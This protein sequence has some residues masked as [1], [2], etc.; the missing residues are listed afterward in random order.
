MPTKLEVWNET[1]ITFL[2]IPALTSDALTSEAARTLNSQWIPVV[3][4]CL[5][6]EEWNF[7]LKRASLARSGSN[8][9]GFLYYYNLPGDCARVVWVSA[10]GKEN[11]PLAPGAF[12]LERN[13]IMSDSATIFVKY[14]TYD[15][16]DTPG[17][18][19]QSFTHLVAA[20]LALS[21][22]KLNTD[23]TKISDA[24]RQAAMGMAAMVD[25]QQEEQRMRRTPNTQWE[26]IARRCLERGEWNF[27]LKRVALTPGG[28][29]LN[30]FGFAN[31]YHL[32][33]DCAR[34][35]WVSE[36]GAENE[37]M[38]PGR[39]T[40]EGNNLLTDAATVYI[41]YVSYTYADQPTTWSANFENFVQAE[42]MLMTRVDP[43]AA[44]SPQA[45]MANI[46]LAEQQAL[47]VDA[48]QS[49]V[50]KRRP[51]DWATANRRR[52]RGGGAGGL[53]E[54]QT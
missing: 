35:C 31:F 50:K 24:E 26:T 13:A 7:A 9:F 1:L 3:R 30:A 14:V 52:S 2:E 5:E 46:K 32:P 38:V 18:W 23:S 47:G 54:Q 20:E 39:Y 34:L 43:K 17:R 6:K 27:A 22:R 41:K 19:S 11:E 25:K 4:R 10:T 40:L 29:G 44:S 15:T 42:V 53:P 45:L 33:T 16:G 48:V 36:T 28:D 49:Q 51:G 12:V 8:T 37:P 21:C